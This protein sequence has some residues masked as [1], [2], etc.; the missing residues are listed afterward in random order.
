MVEEIPEFLVVAETI[1]SAFT[2]LVNPQFSTSAIEAPQV[3]DSFPLSDDFA[4]PMH[5]QVHQEQIVPIVQPHAIFRKFHAEETTQSPLEIFT[6]SSTSTISDDVAK[7]L[8][9]LQNIEEATERAAMLTKRMLEPPL[10]EPPMMEPPL[11]EL[12]M[13]EPDRASAKRRRRT[14]Y[15]PLPGILENAVYLVPS[16]WPPT[17]RA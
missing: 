10:M 5:N 14:R 1:E 16:A 12:P 15:T 8:D 13:M 17:R 7:M 2:G 9:R 6:S 3:V 4:A 11:L